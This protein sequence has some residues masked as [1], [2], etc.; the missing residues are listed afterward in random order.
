MPN[1]VFLPRLF[2]LGGLVLTTTAP[3]DL[4]DGFEQDFSRFADT[5]QQQFSQFSEANENAFARDFIAEWSRFNEALSDPLPALPKPRLQPGLQRA[6]QTE[7]SPAAGSG[8]SAT[9]RRPRVSG[10]FYG[11][12]L[13]DLPLLDLPT[14]TGLQ[15]DDLLQ[16]RE[17]ALSNDDFIE[18]IHLL[19]F[20][21]QRI[22]ADS[23]ASVLLARQLCG[24]HFATPNSAT[25][26]AWILGQSQGLDVRVGLRQGQLLLLTPSEQE[27]YEQ[28]YFQIEGMRLYVVNRRDYSRLQGE[29]YLQSGRHADATET[30]R[31]SLSSS[32]IPAQQAFHTSNHFGVPLQLDED[33]VA[34][35][36]QLPLLQVSD[37]LG[38]QQPNYLLKQLQNWQEVQQ[39]RPEID[40]LK[41]VLTHLQHWPYQIDQEQFGREK[42]LTLSESLF[43]PYTD[44]E[45]RVYALVALNREFIQLEMA[46]LRYPNH[47]SAAVKYQ[48]HWLEADPTYLGANLGMRQPAYLD[49]DPEWLY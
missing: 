30:A 25:A 22:R 4:S 37:Y 6:K 16:F 15:P 19:G 17:Q 38:D 21:R 9:I 29:T 48:G 44:C 34:Y 28:P 40:K 20:T 42:P 45:D 3:A 14:L 11:H 18:L 36:H 33:F 31:I 13:L 12:A 32:F 5:S 46:A 49:M 35:L 23:Y 26:C 43:F 8:P 27:W 24:N 39:E 41:S 2:L 7:S 1:R 47:L 10:G